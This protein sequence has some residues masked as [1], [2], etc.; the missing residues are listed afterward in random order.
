MQKNIDSEKNPETNP[1]A[2]GG[3][4]FSPNDNDKLFIEGDNS[5][6]LLSFE[7]ENEAVQT[8]ETP[9]TGNV[10]DESPA[11]PVSTVEA[12]SDKGNSSESVSPKNESEE[13]ISKEKEEKTEVN[14]RPLEKNQ[15][16]VVT[17]EKTTMKNPE[18][19][20]EQNEEK[21]RKGLIVVIV[22]LLLLLLLGVAGALGYYFKKLK[23]AIEEKPAVDTV[24]VHDTVFVEPVVDTLP[25]VDTVVVEDTVVAPAAPVQ[26]DGGGRVA[27]KNKVPT[28]GYL[29]GYRATADE[30]E[31]IKTV[32]ELTQVEGLP[33]GYYWINDA[34]KG[35]NMFKVYIG[36][37]N[38]E[39]EVQQMLPVI[40]EK[41]PDAHIYSENP[42]I[43]SEMQA[44]HKLEKN[45]FSNIDQPKP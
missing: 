42:T 39:E 5:D 13:S 34:R 4:N 30:V 16:E 45:V 7:L 36:P 22:L 29:I 18:V 27:G 12:N 25:V 26:Y 37:Y 3:L 41:M 17:E 20:E 38:T 15:S 1:N 44:R 9:V 35:K 11:E 8:P 40:K 14:A 10:Q 43:Q 6:D 19:Y 21:S 24:L 28:R 31:A 32:A 33:C 2:D 23:P